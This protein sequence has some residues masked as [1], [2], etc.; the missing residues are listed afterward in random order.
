MECGAKKC[1]QKK[2]TA[3]G[4][5]DKVHGQGAGKRKGREEKGKTPPAEAMNLP[6][7]L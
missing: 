7:A 1:E 4:G 3:R 6:N 5:E 2:K